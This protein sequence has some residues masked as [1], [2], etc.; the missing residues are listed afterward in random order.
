MF[1]VYSLNPF[2]LLNI[3]H[4]EHDNFAEVEI[5]ELSPLE[6]DRMDLDHGMGKLKIP[7]LVLLD[8]S[9]SCFTGGAA[10]MT[11]LSWVRQLGRFGLNTFLYF[12]VP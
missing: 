3:I 4:N 12:S 6:L 9:L 2:P 1:D 10:Q 11:L 7:A 5:N 8:H